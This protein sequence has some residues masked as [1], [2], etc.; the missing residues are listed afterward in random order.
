MSGLCDYPTGAGRAE[1]RT[2]YAAGDPSGIPTR[3]EYRPRPFLRL[4][5]EAQPE[6]TQPVIPSVFPQGGPQESA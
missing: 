3:I 5:F 2:A 4:T 6:A 1:F